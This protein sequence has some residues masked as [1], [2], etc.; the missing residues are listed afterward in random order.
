MLEEY[1]ASE[2]VRCVSR[3]ARFGRSVGHS[4][5]WTRDAPAND[6][7]ARNEGTRPTH[8]VLLALSRVN[9][10]FI[11]SIHS[12]FQQKFRWIS[13]RPGSLVSLPPR[14]L[15]LSDASMLLKV[16]YSV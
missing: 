15:G 3:R 10:S 12:A 5:L 8:R 16:K 14:C 1:L 13:S 2:R 11:R 6:H 4:G 7:A 9:R